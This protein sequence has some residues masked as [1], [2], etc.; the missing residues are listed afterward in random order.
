MNLFSHDSPHYTWG[1][2]YE[3]MKLLMIKVL[4]LLWQY[5]VTEAW[6]HARNCAQ[7]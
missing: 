5:Y 6:Q 7:Y 1:M 2:Y 3:E 4:L